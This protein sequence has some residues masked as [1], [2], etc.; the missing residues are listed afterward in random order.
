MSRNCS[1]EA[2]EDDG[3]ATRCAPRTRSV[4]SSMPP[5]GM[6]S[7]TDEAAPAGAAEAA[8]KLVPDGYTP[9]PA[10]VVRAAPDPALSASTTGTASSTRIRLTGLFSADRGR[11]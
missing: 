5:I 11:A 1:G 10:C 9:T 7:E 6:A 3:I 4:A 2:I 8:P